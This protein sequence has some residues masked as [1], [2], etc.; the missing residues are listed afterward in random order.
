[1]VPLALGR[2]GRERLLG[3]AAIAPIAVVG[4]GG[5]LVLDSILDVA[6]TTS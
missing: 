4:L 6:F 3:L 2:S 1:M 5:Y